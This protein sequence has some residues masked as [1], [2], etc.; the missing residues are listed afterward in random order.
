MTA[1]LSRAHFRWWSPGW[2]YGVRLTSRA[3]EHGELHP[4]VL[5]DSHTTS[6]KASIKESATCSVGTKRI[7]SRPHHARCGLGWYRITQLPVAAVPESRLARSHDNFPELEHYSVGQ[8]MFVHPVEDV[9]V[10]QLPRCRRC[11]RCVEQVC[12]LSIIGRA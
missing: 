11:F 9:T 1:F 4:S 6:T 8:I 5:F 3:E 12:G 7:S 10:A 2:L